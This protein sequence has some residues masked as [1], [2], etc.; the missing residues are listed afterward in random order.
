L[1]GTF[2]V[3]ITADESDG[4]YAAGDLS[5]REAILLANLDAGANTIQFDPSLFTSSSQTI[6]LLTIGDGTVGPSG[7]RVSSEITIV[8]PSGS[9]T[10]TI[11]RDVT[12]P[13]MRLFTVTTTGNL[14]L[15]NV[16]LS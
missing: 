8:G 15:Q 7:L 9:N 6:D 14:T 10:L 3:D 13:N 11:D 12:A 4:N 1:P 16:T 5:L 2:T